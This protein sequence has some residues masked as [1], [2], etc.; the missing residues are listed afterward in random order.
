MCL[1]CLYE[2]ALVN[3]CS[4]NYPASLLVVVVLLE[5]VWMYLALVV[6]LALVIVLA[7][8]VVLALVIVLALVVMIALVLVLALVVGRLLPLQFLPKFCLLY[9]HN[10]I[11]LPS[12]SRYSV[13][14]WQYT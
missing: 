3:Q 12:K 9:Y 11:H 7:L 8:V 10:C 13:Y 6:A 5:S 4:K 14:E 1:G 2:L